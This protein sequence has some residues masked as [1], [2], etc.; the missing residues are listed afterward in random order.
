MRRASLLL[1]CFL[2][3]CGG[4]EGTSTDRADA[5]TP[6]VPGTAA[7][8]PP[9]TMAPTLAGNISLVGARGQFGASAF[10]PVA[11]TPTEPLGPG[12]VSRTSSGTASD[13]ASAGDIVVDV[14]GGARS[15][16]L[17]YDAARGTYDDASFEGVV[18]AGS[19]IAL[20]AAGSPSVPAFDATAATAAEAHIDQPLDG[21]GLSRDATD[22]E[23]AW[24]PMQ[25][26]LLVVSVQIANT[27]IVCRFEATTG[28]GVVPSALI[29]KAV[30][31]AEGTSCAGACASLSIF[32]GHTTK[33]TAGAYDILVTS[34]AN[35]SR[36]LT[37]AK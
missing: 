29:R 24:T 35:V 21:A 12:C 19:A 15:L 17:S 13:G 8:A 16:T 37:L 32:T 23:V 30:R 7:P 14:K 6:G 27:T 2:S 20:H 10:F 33:V 34:G 3:A 4:K 26:P 9:A 25:E 36:V 31:A 22:L 1:A 28:H 18:P 11:P 5:V